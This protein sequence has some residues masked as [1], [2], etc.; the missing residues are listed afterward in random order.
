MLFVKVPIKNPYIYQCFKI[1]GKFYC[2]QLVSGGYTGA[3]KNTECL[4][5]SCCSAEV[6]TA[7]IIRFAQ[8]IA[9]TQKPL[10]SRVEYIAM[11]L[12]ITV[13]I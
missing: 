9:N 4:L 13:Y 5:Q 2:E 3:N 8:T 7:I 10:C 1:A 6:W 11:E 12:S